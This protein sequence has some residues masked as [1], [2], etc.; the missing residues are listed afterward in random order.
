[1]LSTYSI[2]FNNCICII[3][4]IPDSVSESVSEYMSEYMSEYV[5]HY[6]SG[7]VSHHLSEYTS[8]YLSGSV[9][10]YLSG[11]VLDYLSGSVSHYLSGVRLSV[12][13]LIIG[14]LTKTCSVSTNSYDRSHGER[15]Y[16]INV[17]YITALKID[18]NTTTSIN[19]ISKQYNHT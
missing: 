9:S 17:L 6:S 11:S 7:S 19:T 10:H 16:T 18:H 3:M 15:M 14:Q 1:M 8:E 4:H 2:S 12:S 13:L 5:S